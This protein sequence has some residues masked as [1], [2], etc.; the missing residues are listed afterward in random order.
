MNNRV[1]HEKHVF[2]EEEKIWLYALWKYLG[3]IVYKLFWYHYS[4]YH[5]V[6]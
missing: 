4:I 2:D 5:L 1:F 3:V 6:Q